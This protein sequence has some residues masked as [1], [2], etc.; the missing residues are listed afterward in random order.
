MRS[1][2][3][4]LTS[5]MVELGALLRSVKCYKVTSGGPEST[6]SAIDETVSTGRRKK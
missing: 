2:G 4:R 1:H 3:G 6:A 5:L